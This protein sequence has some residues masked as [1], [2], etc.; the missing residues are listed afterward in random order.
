MRKSDIPGYLIDETGHVVINTNDKDLLNYR[1]AVR[2][3]V[4][5]KDLRE[6]I[7]TM[8]GLLAKLLER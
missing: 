2:Q 6:E 1:T 7:D 5:V 3:A 8:K 4:E